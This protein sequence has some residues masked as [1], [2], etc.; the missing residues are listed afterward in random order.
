[1]KQSAEER[2]A[3]HDPDDEKIK[4]G[5]TKN[6]QKKLKKSDDDNVVSGVEYEQRLR[7]QFQ[8]LQGETNW[9]TKAAEKDSDS[10]DEEAAALLRDSGRLIKGSGGKLPSGELQ[11]KKLVDAN[12]AEP[13]GCVASC[14]QFHPNSELLFTTGLDKTLRLFHVDGEVN[15]KLASYHFTNFPITS[16]TFTLKGEQILMT[17]KRNAMYSYDVESG[18]SNH[19]ISLCGRKDTRYWGVSASRTSGLFG[20][21]GDNGYVHVCDARTRHLARSMKMTGDSAALAFHPGREVLMTCDNQSNIYEWD[22]GTGRCVAKVMDDAAVKLSAMSISPTA[23]YVMA[24]G[25]N[26]GTIDL[27]SV[28]ETLSAGQ[29]PIKSLMNLRSEVTT[30]AFHPAGECFAAA[31]CSVRDSLKVFHRPTYTCFRNWPKQTTPLRYVYGMDFSEK[32]GYFAVGN[33]AGK[34]LLYSLSHYSM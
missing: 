10:E 12:V 11:M 16:A 21:C 25:T 14:L 15:A 26:S 5:L 31:A 18:A 3:W 17:G 19:I 1:M 2:P 20:V 23:P 13:A 28:D 9:A 29:K 34:V 33:D 24:V 6:R 32:G 27:F 8:R 7:E 22:L 30:M 4:V